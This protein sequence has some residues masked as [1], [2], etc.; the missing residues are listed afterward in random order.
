MTRWVRRAILMGAGFSL[1]T[2]LAVAAQPAPQPA[3]QQ[4]SGAMQGFQVNRDLPVK[5]ESLTLEVR[6]KQHQATFAGNVKLTQGETT[7]QCKSL[8]VFYE[9]SAPAPAASAKGAPAP[10]PAQK[11]ATPGFGGG[12]Q[13]I[14]RVEARGDVLVTQK[15][16][17]AKGENGVFDI[18][19]NNI[20]LTG[21]VVVTQGTNVLTGERMIVDLTT[22]VTRVESGKSAPVSGLFS[23]SAPAPG[24]APAPAPA[25]APAA[26]K[27]AKPA[28]DPAAQKNA[29][30]TPGAP[31]RI[32]QN[33]QPKKP[34]T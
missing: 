3:Q 25:P 16:Q 18:K 20:T 32:N 11:T 2:S 21:N 31:I 34:A 28:P 29:K 10:A 4:S 33:M 13:Q 6:D 1:A 14:K 27:N 30:P 19:T 24:A 23:P 12:S 22:G 8:V 5:I 17:T 9:D 26:Q 7:I 15:D